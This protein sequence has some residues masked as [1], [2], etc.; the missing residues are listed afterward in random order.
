MSYCLKATKLSK[1]FDALSVLD[2]WNLEVQNGERL[3]IIGPSG[4]GKTTFLRIIARLEI[5]TRGSL[6]SNYSRASYVFQEPRLIPWKTVRD[7]LLFVSPHGPYRQILEQLDLCDYENYYPAQISGG[8]AQRV[9]LARAL[10]NEPDLLILDEAFFALDLRIKYR[11]MDYILS[12]WKEK[13]FTLV[14][15]THDIKDA[16]LLSNRIII[17]TQKPSSIK[18]DYML[19]ENLNSSPIS[20]DFYKM[21]SE[22]A[23]MLLC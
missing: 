23:H 1:S 8:M 11:I 20:T 21:E 15:V 16:L 9:N 14:F 22:L 7:N 3:A 17:L 12:L 13:Q 19:G 10:L 6:L 2:N 18:V 5:P 4:C